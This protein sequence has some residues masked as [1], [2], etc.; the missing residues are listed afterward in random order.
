MKIAPYSRALS[1]SFELALMAAVIL[2]MTT[3]HLPACAAFTP[4]S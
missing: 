4:A 2:W 3:L 1:L